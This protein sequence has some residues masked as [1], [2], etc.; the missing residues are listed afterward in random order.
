MQI[1]P[2]AKCTVYYWTFV[3]AAWQLHSEFL[4]REH[5][6]ISVLRWSWA[7]RSQT[8]DLVHQFMK[9]IDQY[10]ATQGSKR[11]VRT[12]VPTNDTDFDNVWLL[13]RSF[14]QSAACR[15]ITNEHQ[16]TSANVAGTFDTQLLR[17][18]SRNQDPNCD[19]RCFS[20]KGWTALGCN[21]KWIR[22]PKR[23]SIALMEEEFGS[24]LFRFWSARGS[25][26]VTPL[27]KANSQ[28]VVF[29]GI[30]SSQ[31]RNESFRIAELAF[32]ISIM[33]KT[34]MPSTFSEW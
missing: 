3:V 17:M 15:T 12:P 13:A 6:A 11:R 32:T 25:Q 18:K 2:F 10:T 28:L 5:L 29:S 22:E 23:R 27:Q 14:V 20:I 8:M 7:G 33:D 1:E 16:H 21:W 24:V 31:L 9:W 34:K 30:L 19:L 26:A 4:T